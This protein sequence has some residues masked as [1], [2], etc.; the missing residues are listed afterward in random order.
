M[1]CEKA[2][3]KVRVVIEGIPFCFLDVSGTLKRS[4]LRGHRLGTNWSLL[5]RDTRLGFFIVLLVQPFLRDSLLFFV[6]LFFTD[7]IGAFCAEG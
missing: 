7:T 2:G 6:E 1:S 5:V 4:Q 3:R